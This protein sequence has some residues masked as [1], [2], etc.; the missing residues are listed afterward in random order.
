MKLFTGKQSHMKPAAAINNFNTS[1]PIKNNSQHILQLKQ[2][3]LLNDH[4]SRCS[5]TRA[6][7][8]TNASLL[9]FRRYHNF[10][11]EQ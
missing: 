8:P 10:F 9:Q 11:F 1:S 4:V 2:C 3:L 7:L 6:L 5:V